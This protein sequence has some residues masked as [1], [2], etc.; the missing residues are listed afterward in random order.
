[1]TKFAKITAWVLIVLGLLT[2]IISVVMA[3]GGLFRFGLQM[4]PRGMMP[5]TAWRNIPAMG[6]FGGLGMGSAAFFGGLLLI[7]TGQILYLLATLVERKPQ[8]KVEL[9][10][11]S[12]LPPDEPQ[13]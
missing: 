3:V 2:L 4:M 7:G 5:D 13:A 9:N 1:M 10:S 8:A 6:L 12:S 11:V